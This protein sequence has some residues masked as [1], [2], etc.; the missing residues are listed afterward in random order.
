MSA[1]QRG[2]SAGVLLRFWV[3]LPAL[4]LLHS[5][6]C[7]ANEDGYIELCASYG[8]AAG[9]LVHGRALEDEPPEVPKGRR[10][11]L[12]NIVRTVRLLETDE[13]RNKRVSVTCA[14]RQAAGV[15]DKEGFFRIRVESG[16]EPFRPGEVA[17]SVQVELSDEASMQTDGTA[18]VWPSDVARA[19]VCDFDDTICQTGMRSTVK[20]GW[21]TLTGDPARMKPVPRMH[22]F[23]KA[24]AALRGGQAAPVFYVSGGPVNFYPR[25]SAFL[26]MHGFPR[27]ML[28]LRNFGT[29]SD[30]DPWSVSKYKIEVIESLLEQF[31][32]SRF[33][34]VGDSGQKDPQIYAELRKRHPDRIDAVMIRLVEEDDREEGDRKDT[35]LF[36][37]GSDALKGAEAAG[38]LR[39]SRAAQRDV[40]LLLEAGAAV[41]RAQA[42]LVNAQ[43]KDGSWRSDPAITALVVTAM[44]GSRQEEFGIDSQ[45]VTKA[46]AYVRQ[47]AKPDG[48]IYDKFYPNYTTSICVMALIEAGRAEDKDLLDRAQDFLLALQADEG[49]GIAARDEQYGG[50]GYENA[51]SPGGM[52][53]ADLSNTQITLEAVRALQEA[54]QEDVP[55]HGDDPEGRR[56]GTELAFDKA[57]QYLERCQNADGGFIYRPGESKAG[58]TQAGGLRSYGSMTYAGLKSMIHAR[59]SRDDRRVLAACDWA[60]AH[61]TVTENPGL[62]KQG[63][64]YY[65][66]TMARALNVYGQEVIVDAAGKEHDWRAEL[67]DQLLKTQQADGCWVNEHGRWMERIPE[68]VT[69]YALLAIEH[70]TAG[71]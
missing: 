46:L 67:V 7:G 65:Y 17:V 53:R 44:L 33:V 14:G 5:A 66:Q 6:P 26:E 20:A 68:L 41:R 23:V 37:D 55:G 39:S 34:L 1:A 38:L 27:G 64:F 45:P 54:S 8:T 21:R 61:W 51:A 52:Q 18:M 25:L 9:V 3:V 19:I 56:T 57:I 58:L 32:Q 24:L 71:W 50:W 48:G 69:A 60:R 62:G 10:S 11:K 40:S 29:G 43:Q 16:D 15:T 70:A 59:L 36:H 30:N 49:E 12:G 47:F 28:M 13:L 35:I 2:G 63:L 42:Y 31:A 4:C 22:E